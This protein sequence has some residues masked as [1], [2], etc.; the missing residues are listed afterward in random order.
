MIFRKIAKSNIV[1]LS[2][3]E[4]IGDLKIELLLTHSLESFFV[5]S[6]GNSFHLVISHEMVQGFQKLLDL[7][8]RS[9]ARFESFCLALNRENPGNETSIVST[10]GELQ[11]DTGIA[12]FEDYV[13]SF[14]L[15]IA[16]IVSDFGQEFPGTESKKSNSKSFLDTVIRVYNAKGEEIDFESISMDKFNRIFRFF[17]KNPFHYLAVK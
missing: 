15:E 9:L 7:Q 4:S 8:K 13:W 3:V 17:S 12:L 14:K 11:C 10:T 6:N 16:L 2:L 1:S 5:I